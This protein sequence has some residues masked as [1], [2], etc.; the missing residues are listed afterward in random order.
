MQT[1]VDAARAGSAPPV[2]LVRGHRALAEPAAGRLAAAI[3]ELWGVDPVAFRHPERL[4]ELVEDLR[5]YSLFAPGKIVVAVETGVL[6]DREAAATLLAEAREVL[7]WSGGAAELAG[8]ARQ[9]ALRLLQVLRLFDLEPGS[10]PADRLIAQL[11]E[12]LFSGGRGK[13]AKAGGAE[14]R[15]ALEPLLAAAVEAGLRG[16]GESE[17]SLVADLVRDGLP[18]RHLLL[19]VESTAAEGHPLVATLARR[20]AVVDAGGLTSDRGTVSGLER[21]VTELARETGV[22][23][24][25]EAAAELARRTLRPEDERRGGGAVDADSTE[26]FAAEYRKLAALSGGGA[27][28]LATVRSQIEDRGE[29]DVWAILDAIGAGKAGDA[30]A[31]IA[32]RQAGAEDPV[33][34]RLSFFSLLA[35][36][37]R[38]MMAVEGAL[39]ATGARRGVSSY[40]G[41]KSQVAPTIQ[42]A[43]DGVEKNP[44]AGAHAFQLHRAY[45]A[46]ARFTPAELDRFPALLLETERR[47][48]GDSSDADAALTELVVRLSR[49]AVRSGPERSAGSRRRA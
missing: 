16:A 46:S 9:A 44:L 28:E 6:A 37:A 12:S 19:L 45:L 49:P 18:E 34:E 24:R 5:T 3:G 30:L 38:R 26:R 14:Q 40:P 43:I 41:F 35:G 20:E 15:A 31:G 29:Q 27:I 10:A 2:I 8:K 17:A 1:L 42:G 39:K 11:P 25:K 33:L 22:T 23:I 21:L 36:F 7:P 32:R 4:G 48:K 47:L 13:A